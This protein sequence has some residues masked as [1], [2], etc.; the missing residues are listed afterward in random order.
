MCEGKRRIL[1]EKSGMSDLP[2]QNSCLKLSA[3]VRLDK[4]VISLKA[5]RAW[6][7]GQHCIRAYWRSINKSFFDPAARSASEWARFLCLTLLAK[8]AVQKPREKHL[9]WETSI[10]AKP[11][12][13]PTRSNVPDTPEFPTT[14]KRL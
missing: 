14:P 1:K 2:K 6:R 13:P 5:G 4:K 3:K 12:T 7:C 10:A 11:P 8:G 9:S